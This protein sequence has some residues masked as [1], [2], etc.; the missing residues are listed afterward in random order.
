MFQNEAHQATVASKRRS[1][2]E[3]L[4]DVESAKGELR[5]ELLAEQAA[6]L[7][8]AAALLAIS[9]TA[10]EAD[11]SLSALGAYLAQVRRDGSE[12]TLLRGRLERSLWSERQLTLE[13]KALLDQSGLAGREA[14]EECSRLTEELRRLDQEKAGLEGQVPD[15]A[16][17]N[18][19]IWIR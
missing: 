16:T 1:I 3:I 9:A 4:E 7:D 2:V 18:T 11:S 13:L 17:Q 5:D 10:S 15:L 8:A 12:F 19:L 14:T 6:E